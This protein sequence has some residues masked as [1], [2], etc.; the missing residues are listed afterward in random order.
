[1]NIPRM[2]AALT[3]IALT[4]IAIFAT[5]AVL[6]SYLLGRWHESSARP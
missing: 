3:L 6:S 2:F 4:G 1:L 5:F